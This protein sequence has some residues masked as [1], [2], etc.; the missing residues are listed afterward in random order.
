MS[1]LPAS[2]IAR[3]PIERW[4]EFRDLRLRALDTEPAA[5]GQTLATARDYPDELWKSRL[6]D[7][8]EN[9]SWI[10][11]AEVGGSLVGML[12]AFQSE[13]DLERRNATIWGVYVDLVARGKGIST[14]MLEKL[15]SQLQGAGL[16]TAT[17]AVNKEQAAAVRLYER[18]G[19]RITGHE[20]VT[21]GDGL[22]HEEYLM[23]A[24]V[25]SRIDQPD[26]RG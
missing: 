1:D 25:G 16:L 18:A 23:E 22:P 20:T 11:F 5:F 10:V 3:L 13:D 4:P 14:A 9:R 26:Y 8:L 24:L 15:L 19:F 7:V 2:M 12:G 6:L 17:L 21:L